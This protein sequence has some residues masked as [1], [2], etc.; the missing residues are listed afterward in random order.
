MGFASQNSSG[1]Y[2]LDRIRDE[3][4][5]LTQLQID[6]VKNYFLNLFRN[7]WAL[8]TYFR[9]LF[10]AGSFAKGTAIKG[11]SDIDLFLSFGMDLPYDLSKLYKA[12][13]DIALKNEL[14]P[15][16]QRVSI[17]ISLGSVSV[18]LVPGKRQSNYTEDHSL[19][20]YRE[21]TWQKTN[22][23]EQ[24]RYVLA[25]Q[26]TSAIKAFKIWK[27]DQGLPFPSFLVE[28]T[29]IKALQGSRSYTLED[30]CNEVFA[31]LQNKF[32]SAKIEDP[33]CISNIVSDDLTQAEK[34]Q[35]IQAVG[36][37]KNWTDFI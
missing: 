6:N 30:Q 12:I 1:N 22:V 21:N 11:S 24:I 3:S 32:E 18:D 16:K 2:L 8:R 20:I 10:P 33:G 23:K 31:Y 29:V 7:D 27:R 19:H 37:I 36:R 25:A 9:E 26:R 14:R 5:S 35:I 15:R 13:Y 28:L 4:S 34:K 17:G